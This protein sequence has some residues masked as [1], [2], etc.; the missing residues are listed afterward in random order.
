MFGNTLARAQR[1][2]AR[3]PLPLG[4][5]MRV[6]VTNLRIWMLVLCLIAFIPLAEATPKIHHWT[7]DNG[8]R[9]YFVETHEL[10][11][12]QIRAVF[13]AGASRDPANRAGLARLTSAMLDEGTGDLTADDIA[14]RFEGLGAEFGAGV[15]RDMATV[16]LRSLSDSALL[17]PALDLFSKILAGPSFPAGVRRKPRM[18]EGAPRRSGSP[19]RPEPR[20]RATEIPS[21]VRV[22]PA[23]A[24]ESAREGHGP[25]PARRGAGRHERP[26]SPAFPV[27]CRNP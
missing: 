25:S 15:D 8:A 6:R 26:R 24:P 1:A 27:R 5:G 9:V 7:L 17:D 3:L 20:S 11:M 22:S 2:T 12:L 19:A 23:R 16:D 4:E 14:S 18:R 21:G 10:P 13:D